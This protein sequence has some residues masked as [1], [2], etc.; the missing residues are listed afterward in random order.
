MDNAADRFTGRVGDYEKYRMQYPALVLDVLRERCR[1]VVGDVIADVGAGTGMLAKLF[2]EAGNRVIA[3]EPNREMREACERLKV[4]FPNVR[5]VD[6]MAEET[7]LQSGSVDMVSAGRAFHWFDQQRA[8]GEFRRIL[9]PAGWVV[10]VAVR[11]AQEG[12]G[13]ARGYESILLEHGV[14]YEDVRGA[15]R[16]FSGLRPFGDAETFELKIA[17]EQM[18]S[19]EEFLGQ[20]QSLSVTP[21]PGHAKYEGMQE[22]LREYFERWSVDGVLTLPTVCEIVGWRTPKEIAEAT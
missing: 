17:G 12:A 14:D 10:L 6:G 21:M 16:S 22:A 19:L 20:T 4:R 5:I 7:G 11:R 13:R 15:Y 2:L 8:L 18:L 9:K 3:I 1:L